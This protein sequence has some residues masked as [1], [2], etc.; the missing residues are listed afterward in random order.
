MLHYYM[1]LGPCQPN[2]NDLLNNTFPKTYEESG[3]IRSF[4]E[5]YYYKKNTDGQLIHRYWLSYS[6]SLNRIF[7]LTCKLF[8]LP[9]TKKLFLVKNGSNDFKNITRTLSNHE[10]SPD[11]M[12]SVIAHGL[13]IRNDRIDLKLI[14]NANRQVADNRELLRQIIDALIYIGRQNISLR[15]HREGIDSNNRGNFLELVKLLSNN[16]GPLKRHIEQIEGKKKNRLT[17]LSNVTQN[18]LLNIISEVIRSKILN[19]VK[20]SG[21]FAVIIDTTTDVSNLEQFTFI[22]RYVNEEG[23]V[24]ERLVSLVTASD[25]T[26][27]GMF[28]VFCEITNK[29]NIEWKTQLIAQAYDGAAS[30]QGQYS[31]LKTRIQNENPNAIY[32]WC[33]AH[34]FNLVVVDTC[35]CCI[36]S[37]RF[38][39]DIGCF[40]EFMRARKRTAIF[41]KWQEQLYP[42]DRLRRMKRFSTTRWTSHDRVLIVINEKYSALL[43]T[44]E[45]ISDANNS[46]R[47]AASIAENLLSKITSFQFILMMLF[48]RKLFAITS[49]VSRYLQSKEIDFVQAINLID[50]AKNR[51]IDMRTEQDCKDLIDQAKLF[52]NKND[53]NETDFPQVRP[54][55]KKIMAGEQA[56]D[57]LLSSPV[58]N[59]RTGVF[60][61][62]LDTIISSIENRFSESRNIL[63][64]FTLL[65]PE[66]LRLIKNENDLPSDAFKA[67]SNWIS[68]DLTQLKIEYVTFSKSLDKLLNGMNINMMYQNLNN[69][70][71]D[72]DS[73]NDSEN[74]END[75]ETS[76]NK[77]TCLQILKILSSYDLRNAFPNLFKT[78]K[79]LGTIPVS[80][81]SAERSFSKVKLIKTRL[82]STTGQ[83]RL[84][85]L[86][87]LSMERDVPINHQEVIDKFAQT[88]TL[89]KKNLMFK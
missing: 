18:H 66:R 20:R 8:G 56:R 15:G 5:C 40:V 86:L 70:T 88:S 76:E 23:L 13:Y 75:V 4:N 9:D 78:Y 2:A 47:E 7:C 28:E 12:Q 43:E 45:E 62:I 24:Q 65:S 59:F 27:L 32:I 85:S 16:H 42:N 21:Q 74:S 50:I 36:V 53:L 49:E 83:S 39:G 38:F 31:G 54:R 11:H 3:H 44:L 79:A 51:L 25:A 87:M 63:K 6:P 69:H 17:F 55:R 72:F 48:F 37:K 10:S 64:D 33:C 80:S 22:L 61:R 82:R 29:Y 57:E 73:E 71:S 19:E 77:I 58:D 84:E 81:A 30:M 35:D 60:Y 26:G 34:L 14:E 67:I 68:I 89:L 46:D 52:S 41:V 1:S